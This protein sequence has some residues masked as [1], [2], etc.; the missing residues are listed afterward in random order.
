MTQKL[1]LGDF[2]TFEYGKA[3]EIIGFGLRD[4][5]F[6]HGKLSIQAVAEADV[7]DGSFGGSGK[8]CATT[9]YIS[10]DNYTNPR[11]L[12]QSSARTLLSRVRALPPAPSA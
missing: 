6:R 12:A 4:V 1:L 11:K 8:G 2:K 7:V 10:N 3:F 5:A 9:N